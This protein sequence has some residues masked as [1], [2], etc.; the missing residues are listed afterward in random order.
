[1]LGL[2]IPMIHTWVVV[3][4]M[5]LLLAAAVKDA[6]SFTIPNSYCLSLA[7]LYPAHVVSAP[8]PVQWLLALAI[9]AGLLAAGFVAYARGWT[10]G[11]DAKFL[12]AVG[13]WAGQE[14]FVEFLILSGLAGG[15]MVAALWLRHRMARAP[16]LSMIFLVEIDPNFRKQPMPYGIAIAA[17]G[18]Y[19]AFT[20]LRL[21]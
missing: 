8:E 1:M 12:A 10:G 19:V 9:A 7:I 21:L 13:L 2:S 15:V 3:G 6:Q 20:V 14:L 5:A 4:F 16:S 18:L 11:G 17:G